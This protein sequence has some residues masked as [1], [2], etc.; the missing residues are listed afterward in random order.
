MVCAQSTTRESNIFKYAGTKD[1]Q[2]YIPL[3]GRPSN[4]L[5]LKIYPAQEYMGSWMKSSEYPN[6]TYVATYDGSGLL[7]NVNCE[8]DNEKSVYTYS[9]GEL[10]NITRYN[11][12]TGTRLSSEYPDSP[13]HG[14][15]GEER[16]E[17]NSIYF[18]VWFNSEVQG[19][20]YFQST[21]SACAFHDNVY[22][23]VENDE[24]SYSPSTMVKECGLSWKKHT[25]ESDPY[26]PTA[27]FLRKDNRLS[28]VATRSDRYGIPMAGVRKY[29][30]VVSYN[31]YLIIGN[32]Y[33]EYIWSY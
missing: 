26:N 33:Y 21:Y 22:Y 7:T 9:Y 15:R 5:V 13:R 32:N 8:N 31:N 29:A 17:D 24:L 30:D 27:Y 25:R 28:R 4:T 6:K 2:R 19:N 23:T 12:N 1:C 14:K 18:R 20:G 10:N 11:I 16:V 3:Y